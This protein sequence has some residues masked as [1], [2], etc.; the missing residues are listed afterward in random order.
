MEKTNTKLDKFILVVTFSLAALLLFTTGC[1]MEAPASSK[2]S[3]ISS[4]K[5]TCR[6]QI[7]FEADSNSW[8]FLCI[9]H[10]YYPN[11]TIPAATLQSYFK[12]L[13]PYLDENTVKTPGLVTQ[14][15]NNCCANFKHSELFS[16][17]KKEKES[18]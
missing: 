14:E 2:P 10:P 9:G 7:E 8:E 4:K 18:T 11:Q 6:S 3:G 1:D 17:L 5:Y 13:K 15:I 12:L 16:K